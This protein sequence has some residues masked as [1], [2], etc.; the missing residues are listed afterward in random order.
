MTWSFDILQLEAEINKKIVVFRMFR[1]R[2]LEYVDQKFPAFHSFI[3]ANADKPAHEVEKTLRRELDA[4]K[5]Q[6]A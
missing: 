3:L 6:F 5:R 2:G 4:A 1:E